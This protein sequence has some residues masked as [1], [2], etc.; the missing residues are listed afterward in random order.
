MIRFQTLGS[1]DLRNDEGAVASVL[2][3]PKRLALLAY[4]ACARPLG[5]RSRDTLLALFWPE[6][7]TERARNSLRQALHHLRKGVGEA[8]ITTRG[9]RD[10]GID[11]TLLSCDAAQF[12]A[13]FEAA[14]FEEA[15]AVYR[16]DFLP[17]L[18]VQDAPEAARWIDDERMHLRRCAMDGARRLLN[19]AS[20]RRDVEGAIRWARRAV[21]ID[22]ADE[23]AVRRL[24]QA[25]A[26]A[27]DVPAALDAY[28]DLVKRLD[29]DFSL[30]PSVET[31]RLVQALSERAST[32]TAEIAALTPA[33]RVR[34]PR[35]EVAG[36]SA[37][38]APHAAEAPQQEGAERSRP[39]ANAV[40]ILTIL[41]LLTALAIPVIARLTR[42]RPVSGA[43]SIAV[44]PFVNL[45]GDPANEYLSDGLT[46][47]LLHRLAQVPGLQVAA[48][49]STFAFKGRNAPV[50]SIGRVLKV[51]HV[52]EGSV[53]QS[54]ERWRITAQL[55]DAS[56]GYHLWSGNFE[57]TLADVMAVQDSIGTVIVDRLVATVAAKSLPVSRPPRVAEAHVAAMRGWRAFRLNNPDAY[58][59]A[60]GHFREAIA[61]DDSYGYAH[62]GLATV[63]LWQGYLRWANP[64][65]GY[66]E[67]RALAARALALDS[68]LVDGYLVLGRLAEVQDHDDARAESL[69][70]RATAVAPSDPRP[71]LRLAPILV[72]RGLGE[73]AVAMAQRAVTLDPASPAAYSDLANVYVGLGR[74]ADAEA[75]VRRAL[76]LDPGHPILLGNLALQLVQQE[77][78]AAAESAIVAVRAKVPDDPTQLGHHAFI[79]ARLGKAA[80]ARLLADSAERRGAGR[81]SLALT[82]LAVGDTAGMYAQLERGARDGDDGMT[83]VLDTTTFRS[84]RGAP[85]FQRLVDAVRA[86][87]PSQ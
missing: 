67:A 56:T 85:R 52:L 41:G 40:T 46:E 20:D 50:D 22:P 39:W 47:E 61:R 55:I 38:P 66:A 32:T 23:P 4:L 49:T 33:A 18:H 77:E 16:G 3:Q 24:V 7:D 17:G 36:V 64:D 26:D 2:S 25:L 45:S 79:A 72:R 6:A 51:R 12:T 81:V 84:V 37:A 57:S 15:L 63:R 48:R 14:R 78:F 74:S 76:T 30:K 75:A 82:Y 42:T 8:A 59:A 28:A 1:I 71:L 60:I 86:R 68:A 73:E 35:R 34:A 65:S 11:S 19:D 31:T 27:G 5:F 21:A 9:E 44:L 83:F 43:S 80:L 69:Y 10:V 13:A 62:A 87:R 70:R 53:R 29:A 54:G 58:A